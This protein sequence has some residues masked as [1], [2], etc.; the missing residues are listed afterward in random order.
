MKKG[1]LEIFVMCSRVSH[2]LSNN[3]YYSYKTIKHEFSGSNGCRKITVS[4]LTTY[5][6]ARK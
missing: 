1:S 2:R 5:V 3:S 6:P 4:V